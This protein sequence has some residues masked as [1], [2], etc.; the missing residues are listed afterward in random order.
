MSSQQQTSATPQTAAAVKKALQ[1]VSS[2]KKAH[3]NAWFFKTD[4][5][6]YGAGDKFVGVSV[7]NQRVVAKGFKELPLSEVEKLLDSEIHEHRLTG[8]IILVA[9][10]QKAQKKWERFEDPTDPD[11]LKRMKQI[12]TFYLKKKDRVNNW[13]LVDTSAQKIVGAYLF[14]QPLSSRKKLY[15]LAKSKSLWDRRIAVIATAYFISKE[16]Y[17]DILALATLLLHDKEDLMH[18]AIGWMLREMGKRDLKPLRA[19]LDEHAHEMPRPMLRYSI[20]KLADPERK[21]YM[22]AATVAKKK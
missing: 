3:D 10:F 4:D 6:C 12:Y 1:A 15:T 13:D 20:E 22:N 16:E 2:T 21:K 8:L 5:N 11:G 17:E 19:F 9:Q 14:T 18:K 7:P